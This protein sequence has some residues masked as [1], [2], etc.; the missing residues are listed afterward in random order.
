MLYTSISF[1]NIFFCKLYVH[2][3][4]A[5]FT[6]VDTKD[7]EILL[8]KEIYEQKYKQKELWSDF[9]GKVD[10]S[11]ISIV[12]TAL[13]EFKEELYDSIQG[14]SDIIQ[15]ENT[16]IKLCVTSIK[17]KRQGGLLYVK[18]YICFIIC[19]VFHQDFRQTLQHNFTQRYLRIPP[20][21]VEKCELRWFKLWRIHNNISYRNK[22]I[23]E[24]LLRNVL[25]ENY[26]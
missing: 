17:G 1:S 10:A 8:G 3:C 18:R 13:R 26:K 5:G 6:L 16:T 7:K 22:D 2:T 23:P 19:K 15:G 14:L 24:L 12:S 4:G 21:L 11:D 20:L 25:R 9:G